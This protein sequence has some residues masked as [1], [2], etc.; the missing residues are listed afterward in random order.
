MTPNEYCN[1]KEA[2]K[3]L[4][5]SPGAITKLI[6]KGYITGV[7]HKGVWIITTDSLRRYM[8]TMSYQRGQ[9]KSVILKQQ[10]KEQKEMSGELC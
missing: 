2:S 4:G 6:Q 5:I 9:Q 10:Y 8:S 7:K 1:V 3:I